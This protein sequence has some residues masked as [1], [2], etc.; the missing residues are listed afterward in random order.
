LS[1]ETDIF[2]NWCMRRTGILTIDHFMEIF[3]VS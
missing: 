2:R 1:N 3:R